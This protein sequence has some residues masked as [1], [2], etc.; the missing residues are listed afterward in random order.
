EEQRGI[1]RGD[2]RRG[3]DHRVVTL[4]E[5]AEE[6]L[7]ELVAGRHDWQL[8]AFV[9]L[10]RGPLE[11]GPTELS[12]R[13]PNHR[14]RVP[15]A[16]EVGKETRWHALGF[17]P[18]CPESLPTCGE[19]SLELGALLKGSGDGAGRELGG[20]APSAE[21]LLEPAAAD[22]TAFGAGLRPPAR[23]RL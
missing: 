21:L 2:Q 6:A 22:P 17:P 12:H 7:A 23:E 20:N 10:D 15:P 18:K 5:V 11:V 1:G 9:V 19:R 16:Q 8:Y 14:R 13:L 4:P 3:S